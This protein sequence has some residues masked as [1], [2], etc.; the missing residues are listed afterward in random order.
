MTSVRNKTAPR[1]V[2][3][4]ILSWRMSRAFQ[5]QEQKRGNVL[6]TEFLFGEETTCFQQFFWLKD[7]AIVGSDPRQG[8]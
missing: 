2:I 8:S 3:W 6:A 1:N 4:K 7:I 5:H